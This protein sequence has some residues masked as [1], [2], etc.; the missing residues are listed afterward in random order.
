[1][2]STLPCAARAYLRSQQPEDLQ[3]SGIHDVSGNS[4]NVIILT[5]AISM[6]ITTSTTTATTIITISQVDTEIGQ[7]NR[8]S[9]IGVKKI[10]SYVASILFMMVS[11][12]VHFYQCWLLPSRFCIG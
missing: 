7:Q 1:M 3:V 12:S 11:P 8:H 4:A 2:D 6:T 5:G 9:Y 10:F